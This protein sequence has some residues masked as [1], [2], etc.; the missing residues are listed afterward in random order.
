LTMGYLKF[1]L[2]TLCRSLMTQ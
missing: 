1:F 2:M